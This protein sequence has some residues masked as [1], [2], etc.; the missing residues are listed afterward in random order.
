LL[1]SPELYINKKRRSRRFSADKV[2]MGNWFLPGK[3]EEKREEVGNSFSL[4]FF[5]FFF[6]ALGFE[7]RASY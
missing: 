7:L 2:L 4:S 5:F 3:R 6:V 1:P